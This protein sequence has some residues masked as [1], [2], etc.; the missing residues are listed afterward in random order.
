MD[1]KKVYQDLS[2]NECNI[3]QMIKREPEWAA[4]I[5]QQGEIA[6]AELRALKERASQQKDSADGEECPTYE[7]TICMSRPDK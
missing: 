5:L 3:M 6:I 7:G 2:G 4:N 1:L